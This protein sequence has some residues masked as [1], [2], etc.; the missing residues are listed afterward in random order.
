MSDQIDPV[1]E[2]RGYALWQLVA[3]DE[4]GQQWRP[5]VPDVRVWLRRPQSTVSDPAPLLTTRSA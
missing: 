3:N 4:G 2:L 1:L 5:V